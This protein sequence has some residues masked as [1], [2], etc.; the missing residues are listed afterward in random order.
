MKGLHFR[1]LPVL[2]LLFALPALAQNV[3]LI[4]VIGDKA[5]VLALKGGEPKTVKVGQKWNGITVLSV[6]KEQATV[7][8]GGVKRVLKRGEHFG[9]A[10]AAGGK[11]GPQSVILAADPAGHFFIEGQ[12]N[13]LPLRMMLDTGA[14]AI[15]IP[16]GE[17][18]RLG[19]DY[20]K[21]ERGVAQTANGQVAYYRVRLDS[22]KVGGIEI[23]GVDAAVI[24]QG[25]HITLLG[26]TFLNRVDMKRDGQN[27]V[28]T[29]R[30]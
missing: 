30:F 18:Q 1:W 11:G 13:G 20:R 10:A 2:A 6:E 25:L 28:L 27:L 15:A 23:A 19:I 12:V 21:G 9:V 24:E 29:K 4:G 16:G 5:A 3:A 8:I 17:A 7:E 14:T 22:V 26:M